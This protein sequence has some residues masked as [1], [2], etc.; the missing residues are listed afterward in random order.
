MP[1]RITPVDQSIGG[2]IRARRQLRGWSVR[3]TADRAGLTHASLSRIER[4]LQSA[5]NRFVLADIA[6]A[7]ECSVAELTGS[8][9]TL[10]DASVVSARASVAAIRE[11]LLEADFASAST[12]S[13]RALPLLERETALVQDLRGRLDYAGAGQYMPRLIR[14]LHAT[15]D[16]PD[17]ETA[18]RLAVF[19]GEV[20]V[21]LARYTG[22]SADGWL[23]AE[24]SRQAAEAL[25]DPV[26]LGFAAWARTHAVTGCG[27]YGRGHTLATQAVDQL[28]ATALDA[29]NA[30]EMLGLLLLT[31][32]HTAKATKRP[33]EAAEYF[34]EAERLAA[35]TGETTAFEQYFG[36]TNVAFW[37]LGA[38]VDGGDPGLAVEIAA[39][40]NPAL[41]NVPMRQVMFHLDTGRA[42]AHVHRDREAIRS[43]LTAERIGP[44][45]VRSSP[46]AAETARGLLDRAQR[47]AG[48]S[49]LRGLCE[50]LGVGG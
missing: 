37:R 9:V 44:Q 5:D 4:G 19:V 25:G 20:A 7:L 26:L 13:P 40:T 22:Y 35:R 18:L 15:A 46:L 21:S 36:P 23:A 3:F 41:L 2:R 31:S 16:G 10:T 34:A 45:H 38:E 14:E 11:A 50:R 27:A 43:L 1:K 24:W 49:E 8:P 30:L 12:T 17:R 47:R 28:Q 32:A 29:P 48:G 39:T 6:A 42:F 33:G